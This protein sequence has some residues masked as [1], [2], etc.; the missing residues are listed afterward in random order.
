MDAADGQRLA[1]GNLVHRGRTGMGR[2]DDETMGR[3]AERCGK[4]RWSRISTG[5]AIGWAVTM[6]QAWRPLTP[7]CP[8]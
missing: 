7:S 1:A 8:Y 6:R 4:G 5:D 3:V 2:W